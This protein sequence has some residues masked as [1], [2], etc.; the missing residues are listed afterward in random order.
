MMEGVLRVVP[1]Y[2]GGHVANPTYE[3]VCAGSTGHAEVVRIDYDPKRVAYRDLLT[4]FF[5]SHDASQKNRQGDDVG[6]QYRSIIL[7][8]SEAQKAEAEAFIGEL[9]ASAR[10]GKPIVTALEPLHDFYEAEDYHRDYFTKN[11]HARYCE[12]I[13]NPKLEKV[14]KE[15]A[16]LLARVPP[17]Q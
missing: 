1:G 15:F 17:E 8:T 9:N 3:Q 5:A 14:Q 2:A 6:E 10:E 7:Y 12:L 16:A 4:V 13:I 11:P